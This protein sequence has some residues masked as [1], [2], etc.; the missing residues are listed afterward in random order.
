MGKTFKAN[1]ESGFGG[2]KFN[3]FRKSKK[4]KKMN[5]P[6]SPKK[7]KFKKDNRIEEEYYE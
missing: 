3:K 7:N 1:S 4:F 6:Y 2:R 5:D